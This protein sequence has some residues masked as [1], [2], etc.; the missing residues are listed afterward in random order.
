MIAFSAWFALLFLGALYLTLLPGAE[1]AAESG[2]GGTMAA[3]LAGAAVM[4]IFWQQ[5]AGLGHDL[6]HSGVS[7][8]FR[9]DHQVGSS[10][11][12]LMGLSLC[13]WK[14]DHNTHHVVCNAL[15]HDPNIQHMPMLAISSKIFEAPFWDTYHR[16]W[17]GM[18]RIAKWFVSHQHYAFYPLMAFGRLNIYVQGLIYLLA[19]PDTIHYRYTE[20]CGGYCNFSIC[21]RKNI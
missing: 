20:L 5:L 16:R 15:E 11:T 10:L 1:A 8:R 14:S 7:H 2:G 6:G 19:P 18:D 13:W 12:A 4:G 3:H 17:V 9:L 21:E